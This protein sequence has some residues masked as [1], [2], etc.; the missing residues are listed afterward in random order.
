L[1]ALILRHLLLSAVGVGGVFLVALAL[2]LLAPKDA[3][4]RYRLM[5]FALFAAAVLLPLQALTG[6]LAPRANSELQGAAPRVSVLTLG[7]G[8]GPTDANAGAP[9]RPDPALR[10]V[11]EA[12]GKQPIVDVDTALLLIYF[13]GVATALASY[14]TRAMAARR[15]L[16]RARGVTDSRCRRLWDGVVAGVPRP[17]ELLECG[18]LHAPACRALVRPAV[19]LPATA[20]DLDDE[21]LLACLWHEWVHIRRRDGAVAL[22][23]AAMTAGLWF[24][25]MVWLFAHVLAADREHSCDAMVVRATR[26]PRS[27]ALALL[28]FCDPAATARSAVPLIGFESARSIRRRI[29]MLAHASQPATRRHQSLM[30][31]MGVVTLGAASAAHALLTAAGGP[32]PALAGAAR[33]R[34]AG[35][36]Q[37][38]QAATLMR[39][40]VR[41]QPGGRSDAE[42]YQRLVRQGLIAPSTPRDPWAFSEPGDKGV[43][44]LSRDTWLTDQETVVSASDGHAEGDAFQAQHV[45]L[46]LPEGSKLRAVFEG[47]TVAFEPGAEGHY[48]ILVTGGTVQIVDDAGIARVRIRPAS[49]RGDVALVLTGTVEAAEVNFDLE[50]GNTGTP[51]SISTDTRTGVPEGERQP[52]HG[53]I[54]WQLLPPLQGPGSWQLKMQWIYDLSKLP[55]PDG[56]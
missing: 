26:R 42:V 7:P 45:R 43:G 30:L 27:Y 39:S 28:R 49:S 31:C 18:D 21:T 55:R 37:D 44:V 56:C 50:T 3:V 16:R 17:P 36:D 54:R 1:T 34:G 41:A 8:R 53:A 22:L 15:L 2:R 23:A 48:R 52:P 29:T 35:N 9:V 6:E 32:G 12:P 24:Q 4:L 47:R 38:G 13:A 40:E 19:I 25:P 10:R 14:A 11:A 33:V 46:S 51:V 20:C 5:V